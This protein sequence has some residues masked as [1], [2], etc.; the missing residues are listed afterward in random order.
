M[1][2]QKNE[3]LPEP[4]KK[5]L[6]LHAQDIYRETFNHAWQRY[7]GLTEEGRVHRIAWAAVKMEYEKL[8][9]VWVPKKKIGRP[10]ERHGI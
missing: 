1:P 7:D 4:V 3:D 6:P 9:G 10:G 2:Y 5:H 8:H